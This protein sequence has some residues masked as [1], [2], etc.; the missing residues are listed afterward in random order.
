MKSGWGKYDDREMGGVILLIGTWVRQY[1]VLEVGGSTWCLGSG[2]DH[3]S[4][5]EVF[6]NSEHWVVV[7]VILVIDKWEGLF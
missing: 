4:D 1:G 7:S 3:S 2:W 5:W 6:R